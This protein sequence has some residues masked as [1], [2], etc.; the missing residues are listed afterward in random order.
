MS[1]IRIYLARHLCTAPRPQKEAEALAAAGHDV[2]VHGVAYDPAFARRDAALA[3]G[4]RWR[5]E[6]VAD[7]T[8]TA[9]SRWL[10]WRIC[11]LRHRLAK[12]WFTLTG[13][14]ASDVWSNANDRLARH[15]LASSADLT[16]VHAE[17]GLWFGRQL[18]QRGARVG[19]DFEDW[20]SQDL[21]PVQ[22]RG[23]PVAELAA[24]ERTLL[25]T[26]RYR[27][28]TSH[29]LA[30]ALAEAYAAPPPDVIYNTFPAGSPPPAPVAAPALRLHW[31]SLVLGPDRGLETLF[32]ALPRLSGHWQLSLRGEAQTGYREHLLSLLPGALRDRVAFQPTVAAADLPARLAEHDIGLALDVSSIPSRNLTITNKFFHYLHAGLAVAATATAGHRE[33]LAAIPEAGALFPAGDA[34]ALARLLNRWEGDRPAMLEARRAARAAFERHFSHERQQHRYVE[35]AKLALRS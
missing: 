11:R 18:Q 29:C 20:F 25:Q 17:G 4:R 15:A 22:R 12:E 34:E 8:R 21:T 16:I 10:A 28:T 23:R 9:A 13:R 35:L 1:R 5:W 30:R 26:A 6:P 27:L 33:A 2:S 24:L 14:I 19:V 32:A 31:F 7:F 3:D